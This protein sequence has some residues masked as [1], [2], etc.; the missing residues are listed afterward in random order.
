MTYLSIKLIIVLI[1]AGGVAIKALREAHKRA[2]ARKRMDAGSSAFDD[3]AL[4][5]LTGTVQAAGDPLVAPLSGKAC[6]AHRTRV[7]LVGKASPS[8]PL[9]GGLRSVEGEYVRT[10]LRSFRLTT[11]DGDVVIEGTTAELAIRPRPVIPRQLQRELAFLRESEYDATP[12][13]MTFDEVVIEPGAT[14]KV[15]G[16]ARVEIASGEAQFREALKIRKLVG[17]DRHP[18]TISER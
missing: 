6:V 18:L 7:R 3:M 12:D 1:A 13:E 15:H 2:R 10:E 5:T 9:F 11:R 16:I 14:I 8:S 17:D 4:V